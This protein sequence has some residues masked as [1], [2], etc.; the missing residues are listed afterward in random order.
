MYT[1]SAFL[2]RCFFYVCFIVE[3]AFKQGHYSALPFTIL[4]GFEPLGAE[5]VTELDSL[6]LSAVA[7]LPAV[8]PLSL[9]FKSSPVE[10]IPW[11]R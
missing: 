9:P 8:P 2:E 6:P 4:S 5:F 7:L 1:C 3:V 11:K 10:K